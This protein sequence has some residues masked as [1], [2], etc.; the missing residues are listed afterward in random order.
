M[1]SLL[2]FRESQIQQFLDKQ[3]NLS[4]TYPEVGSTYGGIVPP[5]YGTDKV[6]EEIGRGRECFDR[7]VSLMKK[8]AEYGLNWIEVFP[9]GVELQ[10]E[11]VVAVAAFVVGIWSLNACRVIYVIDEETRFGFGY[12]T[13]PDHA[14]IGEERFLIEWN[15]ETDVVTYEILVFSNPSRWYYWLVFPL[16]RYAQDKFRRESIKVL[17]TL[18]AKP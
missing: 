7:C 1:L 12:G 17:K 13:L 10:A 14:E 6:V 11:S 15:K 5:G 2:K 9:H 3:R 18:A 8:W 4:L 16:H